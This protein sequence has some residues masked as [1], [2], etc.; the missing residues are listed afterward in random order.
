[1]VRIGSNNQSK[2]KT[3]L[4]DIINSKQHTDALIPPIVYEEE[5]LNYKKDNSIGA[6]TSCSRGN[7]FYNKLEGK[8]SVKFPMLAPSVSELLATKTNLSKPGSIIQK[9]A[10]DSND[11]YKLPFRIEMNCNEQPPI[12]TRQMSKNS[13]ASVES[14]GIKKNSSF[15]NNGS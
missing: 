6:F 10:A 4:R 15:F 14:F 1:V 9:K 11:N 13:K 5:D 8:Q 3:S 7:S 12:K 2:G